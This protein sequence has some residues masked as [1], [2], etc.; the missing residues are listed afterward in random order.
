M[1]AQKHIISHRRKK[2][3]QHSLFAVTISANKLNAMAAAGA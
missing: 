2:Q 1:T 3:Q